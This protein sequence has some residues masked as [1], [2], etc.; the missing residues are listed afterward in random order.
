MKKTNIVVVALIA[1]FLAAWCCPT[2]AWAQ[3]KK[4]PKKG[5]GAGLAE[6][7]LGPVDWASTPMGAVLR[8]RPD[9]KPILLYVYPPGTEIPSFFDSSDIKRLSREEAVFCKM[10]Y[11]KEEKI[12]AKLKID[13]TPLML[14]L[15]MYGNEFARTGSIT[16]N[17]ARELI[18][19]LPDAVDAYEMQLAAKYDAAT[20]AL[21]KGDVKAGKKLLVDIVAPGKRGYD[22]INDAAKKLGELAEKDFEEVDKLQEKDKEA[23]KAK[24]KKL[25]EEYKGTPAAAEAEVRVAKLE[26]DDGNA[27]SAVKRILAVLDLDA[28]H[29]KNVVEHAEKLLETMIKEGE[30]LI[31]QAER[32]AQDGD[33]AKAKEILDRVKTDYAGTSLEKKARNA[34]KDLK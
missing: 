9:E 11:D 21:D 32:S 18:D 33:K 28:D 7:L 34:L 22:D 12:F 31:A 13:K 2:E 5:K 10:K 23:A 29:F 26:N 4:H 15:D 17:A 3:K 8:A 16:L 14:G 19:G 30:T 20:R 1:V 25:T 6:E 27:K 24:L